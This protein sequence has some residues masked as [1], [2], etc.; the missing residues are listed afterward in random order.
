MATAPSHPVV[1]LE[2]HTGDM[3]AACAFYAR[4]CGWRPERVECGESS[5][6]AMAMG[7][8][9]D[10][11]VVECNTTRPTW[12]PY[13]EV[14]HIGQATERARTL[15]AAVLLEPREG[16]VGWRSIIDSPTAGE[17]A[18]WQPKR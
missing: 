2:L 1:H 9:M 6:L 18:F 12:L 4:L 15:G 3:V 8:G 13:V 7:G 5:Y 14:G 11:G 10:A 17:I 16:P